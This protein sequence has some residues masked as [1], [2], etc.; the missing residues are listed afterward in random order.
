MTKV[1]LLGEGD[2]SFA[3]SLARRVKESGE[4]GDW[5]MT[6]TGLDSESEVLTKY[7]ESGAILRELRN[8]GIDIIF[9]VDA[10]CRLVDSAEMFDH[11][12]FTFPHLAR[13][14]ATIH[15]SLLIHFFWA[16]KERAKY[17]HL[18]LT[19][20]Q[21]ERWHPVK[22]AESQGLMLRGTTE[23]LDAQFPM[24][25]RRRSHRGNSFRTRVEAEATTLSFSLVE[26]RDD[27][28]I[29]PPW[30]R[31]AKIEIK[32][33]PVCSICGREFQDE[34]SLDKHVQ[35]AP[36]NKVS[37]LICAVCG[38]C[39]VD[40]LALERHTQAKHSHLNIAKPWWWYHSNE[41]EIQD[42]SSNYH[43]GICRLSF[44]S[45]TDLEKHLHYDLRPSLSSS[46]NKINDN[47]FTSG[48]GQHQEY[49]SSIL[50]CPV[51]NRIFKDLRAL[52]QHALYKQHFVPSS[53]CGGDNNNR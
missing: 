3:L 49:S 52:Q 20:N 33:K 48:V 37:D 2:F 15:Y 42:P 25:T 51:C 28:N 43:C 22:A 4:E 32:A 40:S 53:A 13:E 36:H 10:T 24:Y 26:H 38:Q 6:A 12:L 31:L 9:G 5:H 46:A 39:F 41:I 8:L 23:F 34:R 11:I 21:V 18:T 17:I 16:Y 7:S 19:K 27:C 50:S 1:L 45:S 14:D 29:E 44:A 30:T 47:N 35:D